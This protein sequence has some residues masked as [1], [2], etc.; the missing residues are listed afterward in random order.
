MRMRSTHI[1][2]WQQRKEGFRLDMKYSSPSYGGCCA[3]LQA[4]SKALDV[5][6]GDA[7]G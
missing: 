5:S 2:E 6:V 1:L 3:K 7:N 4:R